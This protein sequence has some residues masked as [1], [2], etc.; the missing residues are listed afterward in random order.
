MDLGPEGVRACEDKTCSG[1]GSGSLNSW[2]QVACREVHMAYHQT[3]RPSRGVS[4]FRSPATSL[5]PRNVPVRVHLHQVAL[6]D[7]AG[8]L[9]LD[10]LVAAVAHLDAH[11]PA[12]VAAG[13]VADRVAG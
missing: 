5:D 12:G 9:D 13:V 4:S 7:A 10:V 3:K 1:T 2:P 6:A 8:V 11:E